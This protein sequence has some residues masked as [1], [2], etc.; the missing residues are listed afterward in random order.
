MGHVRVMAVTSG[1]GGVGKT[2]VVVNL[3][4]ALV[5]LRKRVLI[6]DADL[7]LG[8]LDV[9]LGLAPRYNLEHVLNGEQDISDVLVT[10]PGGILIL[11]ATSGVQEMT[12]LTDQ[13]KMHLLSQLDTLED[14]IDIMLIDTGAG[15]SN[16]VTYF[17]TAAQDIVVVASPEPTSITDAYALMKVLSVRYG[18]G[19]F[20]LLANMVKSPLE[21]KEIY[22][23]LTMV[24]DRYL[25][26]SLDYL[27]YIL[28]D[29][30][31]PWAVREQR[32]VLDL[33]PKGR[34]SLCFMNL[35]ETICGWSPPVQLKGN[36]QFFWR[37]L[38]DKASDGTA[39]QVRVAEQPN[40]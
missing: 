18:E 2:N 33:F 15:I 24:A 31:V 7:G 20:K 25:N 34:A 27:G 35:A 37:K 1:K 19:R 3:A 8:N 12:A 30:H 29:D 9:L 14:R 38:I 13:Q 21:G 5:K 4:S 36:I 16:N 32:A 23:K 22:R 11:P 39:G 28:Q 17:A 6:L 40:R 26:I 10:G